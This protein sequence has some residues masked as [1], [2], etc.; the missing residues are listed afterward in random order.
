MGET[1]KPSRKI[2]LF[3]ISGNIEE[4]SQDVSS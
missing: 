3:R 2:M 4:Q 1:D